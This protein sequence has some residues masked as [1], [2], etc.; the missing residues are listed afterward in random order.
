MDN[1][2]ARNWLSIYGGNVELLTIFINNERLDELLSKKSGKDFLGLIPSWLNCYDEDF[3]PSKREK[4]Y[5]WEQTKLEGGTKILP[6]LLCPDDFDF[7]CTT[8]VVE[9]ID[10][11]DA[12]VWN[13]F[14]VDMTDFSA[15]ESELPKYIG[16]KVEWFSDIEPFVFSKAEYLDCIKAFEYDA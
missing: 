14:G 4:Q 8:V 13:R 9:V 15:D 6:I 10:K 7:S 3:A 2:T 12:V 11:T 16:K 1:I 5:V